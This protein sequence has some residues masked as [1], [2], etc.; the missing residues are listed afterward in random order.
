LLQLPKKLLE[1]RAFDHREVLP[2]LV[3]DPL[4]GDPG[5]AADGNV[6]ADA[7]ETEF[8]IEDLPGHSNVFPK[9][10]LDAFV[11]GKRG[12]TLDLLL[13][14]ERADSKGVGG[15]HPAP[16]EKHDLRRAP[17]NLENHRVGPGKLGPQIVDRVLHR[18]V[19]E[20]VFLDPLD[21]IDPE[22]RPDLHAIEKGVAVLR[23]P[24][25]RRRDYPDRVRLNPPS[26]EKLAKTLENRHRLTHRV[27]T[28][29]TVEEDIPPEREG[30]RRPVEGNPFVVPSD[31]GNGNADRGG[32]DID[33]RDETG[34]APRVSRVA[35]P[36]VLAFSL[37]VHP[38]RHTR[39]FLFP[40]SRCLNE[41]PR[42]RQERIRR[43]RRPR[44][45]PHRLRAAPEQ[46]RRRLPAGSSH[47][48]ASSPR[49]G[50]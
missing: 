32:T 2:L 45:R 49:H 10:L 38:R 30:P 9:I 4:G 19:G 25:R 42:L 27:G 24:Y 41:H 47:G 14:P 33:H 26:L 34:G 31:L 23:L 40:C 5:V 37:V 12:R 29:K 35:G 22:P 16:L 21:D 8:G 11:A 1:R 28:E 17:A 20:V 6:V 15:D 18:D 50:Q 43:D 44:P 48:R 46:P 13:H 39:R 7:V 36:A 3:A